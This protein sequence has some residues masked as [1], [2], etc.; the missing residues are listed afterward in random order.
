MAMCHFEAT[1]TKAG[2]EIHSLFKSIHSLNQFV[3]VCGFGDKLQIYR[4]L[5]CIWF[6]NL[7]MSLGKVAQE[8]D[9]STATIL[10][11]NIMAATQSKLNFKLSR[12]CACE[13]I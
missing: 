2:I 8:C 9:D 5:K 1:W 12:E 6:E 4:Q 13:R 3:F 11:G 10:I 7:K